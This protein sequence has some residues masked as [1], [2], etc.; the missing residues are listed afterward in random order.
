MP[1]FKIGSR[2]IGESHPTYVIAEMSG[3]HNQ[4]FDEAC[5]IVRAAAEAGADALKLQTYTADTITLNVRNEHFMIGEGTLWEGKNLHDLYGEA[6]TPWEWQPRLKELGESLGMQVFSSPFDPTSVDFLE[7]MG[8][9]AYKIAS[10]EL[11]DIPLIRY[12]AGKGKP[13]I[14]STGMARLEEIQEAVEAAREGGCQELALLKCNS[15]YPAPPS[16]MNLNTI[17]DLAKR[18]EVVAGLSDHT[19]GA[20][21]AIASVALGARIIEKHFTLSRAVPGPDSAFSMEPAEF[22][23]MVDGVREAEQ[24]LGMVRYEITEKEKGSRVFRK[25]IFVSQDVK[26]GERFSTENLRCVRPGNGLHTRHFDELMGRAATQDIAAG[27]PM[28]LEFAEEIPS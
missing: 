16:E 17:P 8:V 24:A 5:E 23:V 26:Q 14:M 1:E 2:Q 27:T 13:M 9:E 4:N 28:S 22:K 18:F 7:E 10:F 20:A 11:V 19:L 15:A 12:V 3:N 21:A 6:F 25:S